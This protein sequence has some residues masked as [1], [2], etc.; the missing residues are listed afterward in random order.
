MGRQL[1][2]ANQFHTATV[3]GDVLREGVPILG[4]GED[5]GEGGKR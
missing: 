5:S 2:L 1:K 3:K 4:P